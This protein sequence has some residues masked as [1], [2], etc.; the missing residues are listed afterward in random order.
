MPLIQN[1]INQLTILTDA[2]HVIDSG[3]K[4]DD[5]VTKTNIPNYAVHLIQ[6]PSEKLT[7]STSTGN[8]VDSTISINDI[9]TK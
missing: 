4:V 8:V 6:N 5:V 1:P 2:G 9:I 3:F 7:I